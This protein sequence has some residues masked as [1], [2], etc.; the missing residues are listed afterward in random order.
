MDNDEY[1]MMKAILAAK[2]SVYKNEYPFG[3]CI[4]YR[5]EVIIQ[6]NTSYTERDPLKHAEINAINYFINKVGVKQLKESVIYTTTEPCLM[7]LGAISWC[8]IPKLVYGTSIADSKGF[9]FREIDMT[10]GDISKKFPY[11][12]EIRAGV[13]KDECMELLN[14]WREKNKVLKLF[15]N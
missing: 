1:Y 13:L 15:S 6:S 2:Q 4:V 12:I 10:V 8:Q 9:N 11:E 14:I 7:C 3:C 5:N